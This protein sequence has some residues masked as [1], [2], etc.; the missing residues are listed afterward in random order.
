MNVQHRT[1]NAERRIMMSLRSPNYF[2]GILALVF[3]FYSTFDVRCSFFSVKLPQPFRQKNNLAHSLP[4]GLNWYYLDL[5]T[6]VQPF[7]V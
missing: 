1:L 6:L 2:N 5:G 4:S 3:I 7:S